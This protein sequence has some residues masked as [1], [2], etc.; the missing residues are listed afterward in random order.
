VE[1][2][3]S[4]EEGCEEGVRAGVPTVG[5]PLQGKAKGRSP[6]RMHLFRGRI[7][8]SPGHTAGRMGGGVTLPMSDSPP[9]TTVSLWWKWKF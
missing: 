7:R 2:G 4:G 3:P 6:I 8:G 1:E 5:P 9:V